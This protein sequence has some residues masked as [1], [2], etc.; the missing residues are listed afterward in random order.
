MFNITRLISLFDVCLE[1]ENRNKTDTYRLRG[2]RVLSGLSG[3]ACKDEKMRET[4]GSVGSSDLGAGRMRRS[5]GP[6]RLYSQTTIFENSVRKACFKEVSISKT[7]TAR[8]E[9]HKAPRTFKATGCEAFLSRTTNSIS[10]S[11]HCHTS[12]TMLS[13]E[14]QLHYKF[15]SKYRMLGGFSPPVTFLPFLSLHQSLPLRRYQKVFV[16]A[17][18]SILASIERRDCQKRSLHANRRFHRPCCFQSSWNWT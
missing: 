12:F 2:L 4:S 15:A 5:K 8:T 1:P 3:G 17:I 10:R 14:I 13:A 6:M 9:E 18:F 7:S 11:T 16:E